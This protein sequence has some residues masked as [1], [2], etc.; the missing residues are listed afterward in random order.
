MDSRRIL[1]NF[2]NHPLGI[3][4]YQS[5]YSMKKHGKVRMSRNFFL[6]P[7][8]SRKSYGILLELGELKK[9]FFIILLLYCKQS[10][11]R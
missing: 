6:Y 5:V 1:R 8:K 2:V 3:S 10:T 9:I 11:I 7:E 4:S